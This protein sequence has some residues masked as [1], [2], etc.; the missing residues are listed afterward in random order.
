[1]NADAGWR[2]FGPYEVAL[3]P[4]DAGHATVRRKDGHVPE[5]AWYELLLMKAM[6]FGSHAMAVELFPPNA[7]VIDTRHYRHLWLV[8]AHISPP[9]IQAGQE[10]VDP[11]NTS[12]DISEALGA[13]RE[14]IRQRYLVAGGSAGLQAFADLLTE[15]AAHLANLGRD[16]SLPRDAAW[17]LVKYLDSR[18]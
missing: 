2:D 18:K 9:S 16:A 4:E 7:D 13:V 5:P 1:M 6:I 8:P 11:M 17:H 14:R 15:E 12:E 10:R 3:D